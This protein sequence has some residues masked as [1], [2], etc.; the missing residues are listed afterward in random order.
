[1]TGFFLWLVLRDVPFGEVAGVIAD[2]N[3]LLLFGLSIPSY[4]LVVYLRALRWKLL[5]AP[6]QAYS[7][8]V[9]FRAT[10]VGFMANNV[11]PPGVPHLN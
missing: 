7:T 6:V 2:A 3:L 4:V 9:L 10:A 5:A 1:M 11:F 8:G